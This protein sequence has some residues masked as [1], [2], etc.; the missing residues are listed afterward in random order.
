M[1]QH[2]PNP[3]NEDIGKKEGMRNEK[4]KLQFTVLTEVLI[5]Y[6]PSLLEQ[7]RQDHS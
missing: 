4:Q 1:I 6:L 2:R 7:G 3:P 5:S